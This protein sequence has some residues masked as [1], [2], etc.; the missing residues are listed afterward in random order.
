[1]VPNEDRLMFRAQFQMG[2]RKKN[3]ACFRFKANAIVRWLK[4]RLQAGSEAGRELEPG[5]PITHD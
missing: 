2:L 4:A 5:K 1:M 3:V